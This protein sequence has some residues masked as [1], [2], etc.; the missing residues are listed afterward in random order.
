MPFTPRLGLALAALPLIA[1]AAAAD[2]RASNPQGVLSAMQAYGYAA[3]LET[4]STGDPK[5][6]SRVSRSN[7]AVFFYGCSDNN[8][9]AS[10]QFYTGYNMNNAVSAG[11]MNEWN[12]D[13]LFSKATVDDDGDPALE[14]DVNL[15]FDGM[16]NGNFEDVLDIWRLSVESFEEFIDW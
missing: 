13:K 8:D 2:V 10:I 14:M 1:T 11:R 12:R 15:D 9:C 3:T 7:F 4:D 16:G 6:S 5:I